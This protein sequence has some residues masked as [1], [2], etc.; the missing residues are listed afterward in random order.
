MKKL[1]LLFNLIL[2]YT[3]YAS[4]A[5]LS[6]ALP[7]GNPVHTTIT[8][9][10]SPV[11]SPPI[12]ITVTLDKP[13]VTPLTIADFIPENATISSLKENVTL[14]YTSQFGNTPAV[15]PPTPGSA[16]PGQFNNPTGI[17]VDGAGQIYVTDK[18]NNRVEVFSTNGTLIRV[19]GDVIAGNTPLNNPN[20]IALDASGKIYVADSGNDRIVVFTPLGILSAI[21]GSSGSGNGKLDSPQGVY[22]DSGNN[23]FVADGDNDRIDVFNA[24]NGNFIK[25]IGSFGSGNGQFITPRGVVTDAAGFIYV[26]DTDN[27]RVQKFSPT[28][29]FVSAFGTHGTDNNQFQSPVGI[30]TDGTGKLYVADN[31]GFKIKVF[32]TDGIFLGSIGD[33]LVSGNGHF[34]FPTGVAADKLGNIYVA[35]QANQ[36]VQILNVNEIYALTLTPVNG[37]VKLTL[38]AD[39]THDI[40]GNG[41][42]LATYSVT[43]LATPSVP[44]GL[45]ATSLDGKV[46]LD[47]T[48]NPTGDNLISYKIFGG[49]DP[50]N[51]LSIAQIFPATSPTY[52]TTGPALTNGQTY[53]YAISAFNSIATSALSTAVSVTPKASQTISITGTIPDK[54]YGDA[55]FD[56][57]ALNATVSSGL[58]ITYSILSTDPASISGTLIT[59]TG[60]GSV[61]LHI[62]QVGN[63]IYKPAELLVSFSV[64]QGIPQIVWSDPAAISYG[65]LLSTTQ[66]NAQA[67]TSAGV[68]IPGTFEYQ[69]DPSGTVINIG[70]LLAAGNHPAKA[71]FHPTDLINYTD[72]LSKAGIIEVSPI[73]PVL[74]W[75]DPAAISYGTLLSAT[76]LNAQAKTSAGVSIP[77]SFEYQLDPSG[78]VIDIGTLLAVGSH[79]AKAIFHPTD[80]TTY[81]DNVSHTATIVVNPII[82][83]TPVTP[84]LTWSDPTAISYGTLLSATQLNAQAKTSAG[85]TISGSFE[86]QLD[87]SGTV[88]DIGT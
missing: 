16:V 77:G 9:P 76:Q 68:T 69:L 48:A 72:N 2:G 30:T 74:T 26:V 67:K 81:A 37:T 50:A 55:P 49:T 42:D 64:T 34:Y 47:W 87:P 27:N 71:I 25:K 85:V 6:Y 22:V 38:D 54:H 28:G 83:V 31:Q 65:T 73:T 43:Y 66:L 39:K 61:T 88:I 86:Y 63:S 41:N 20:G 32:N 82:P 40:N 58:P 84:V 15:N 11:N 8:G 12:A 46:Q 60:I 24:V 21:I 33:D 14:T 53:Y 59:L 17:T 78:T 36:R 75:S 45:T 51:L 18:L 7:S 29:V 23:L 57:A 19:F 56:I 3:I 44:I 5:G 35:D 13:V 79:P 4:A 70:T 80:V 10:A 1:I 62:I 52:V